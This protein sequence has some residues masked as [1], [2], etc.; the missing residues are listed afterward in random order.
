MAVLI[1]IAALVGASGCGP[2]TEE[3]WMRKCER[4]GGKVVANRPT[5][6]W[7]CFHPTPGLGPP[8]ITSRK[9]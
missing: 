9:M 7:L 2:E 1:L 3:E 6:E 8:K 5:F 4:K